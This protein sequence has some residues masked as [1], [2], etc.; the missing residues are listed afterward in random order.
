LDGKISDIKIFGTPQDD[1]DS[2]SGVFFYLLGIAYLIC[3]NIAQ[4]IIND[5]I[6]TVKVGNRACMVEG[7]L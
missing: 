2:R 1:W 3:K 4:K 7:E 6:V 5:I